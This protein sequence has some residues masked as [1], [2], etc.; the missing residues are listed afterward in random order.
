MAKIIV[1]GH[2]A[3]KEATNPWYIGLIVDCKK[4]GAKFEL[5]N[6]DKVTRIYTRPGSAFETKCPE[7]NKTTGFYG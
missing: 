5:E 6:N 2:K 1:K 7:C 3:K 4:C